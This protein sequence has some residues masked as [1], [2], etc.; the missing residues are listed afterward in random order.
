[1]VALSSVVVKNSSHISVRG[2][3]GGTNVGVGGYQIRDTVDL[4]RK[5]SI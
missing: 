5:F 4:I 1:M 2:L 3:V